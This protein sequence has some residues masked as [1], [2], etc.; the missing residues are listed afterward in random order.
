MRRSSCCALHLVRRRK[1]W[2]KPSD[3]SFC[4]GFPNLGGQK[5]TN[6]TEKEVDVL[7]QD[8][9]S[10]PNDEAEG[11]VTIVHLAD[12]EVQLHQRQQQQL[13]QR[14]DGGTR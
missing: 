13:Q 3:L 8:R 14:R 2:T 10:R 11:S 4:E 5:K 1:K 9:A 7:Q 6:A 12:D